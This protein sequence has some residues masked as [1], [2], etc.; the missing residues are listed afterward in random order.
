MQHALEDQ[1]E[2]TGSIRTAQRDLEDL[3]DSM[4]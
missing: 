4:G 2:A 3:I 1:E